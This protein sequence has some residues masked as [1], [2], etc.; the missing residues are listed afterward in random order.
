MRFINVNFST[1]CMQRI[2]KEVHR[3]RSTESCYILHIFLRIA[4]N[5]DVKGGKSQHNCK[6][7]SR[8][9]KTYSTFKHACTSSD[10]TGYRTF[11]HA[12]TFS[13]N[14]RYSTFEHACTSSDNRGLDTR[15]V[16]L[17]VFNLVPTQ[18]FFYPWC[19]KI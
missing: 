1:R 9:R 5:F 10:N 19:L 13:D 18:V 15:A 4:I 7:F 6:C 16:T 2:V 3:A 11:E 12:C 8:N 14:T 17:S